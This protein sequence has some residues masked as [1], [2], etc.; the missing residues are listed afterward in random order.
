[1]AMQ[2]RESKHPYDNNTN[3]EVCSCLYS[4]T[5]CLRPFLILLS[6]PFC[7][8]P[9]FSLQPASIHPPCRPQTIYC[10]YINPILPPFC[11]QSAPMQLMYCSYFALFCQVLLSFSS[12]NA[13]PLLSF[14]KRFAPQ[15]PESPHIL[16]PYSPYT[17]LFVS[18]PTPLNPN[19]AHTLSH[20]AVFCFLLYSHSV[21]TLPHS[22]SQHPQLAPSWPILPCTSPI[23]LIFSHYPGT[24]CLHTAPYQLIL[25]C[26]VPILSLHCPH[27][28]TILKS[29]YDILHFFCCFRTR[30]TS[31]GLFTCL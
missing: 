5:F 3:F 27:S 17:S 30:C 4:T 18:T 24:F 15:H 20:P 8:C 25:P 13:S 16:L 6:P 2:V 21:L 29:C 9:S 14:S 26:I 10:P 7:L 11:F 19:S 28:A 23:L 1:M 31:L 22:A 12:C